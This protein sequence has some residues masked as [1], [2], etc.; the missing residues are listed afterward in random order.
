MVT[1]PDI[2]AYYED[3]VIG[4]PHCFTEPARDPNDFAGALLRKMLTEVADRT[5]FRTFRI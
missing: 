3:Q 2:A 1:E 4:G 5:V